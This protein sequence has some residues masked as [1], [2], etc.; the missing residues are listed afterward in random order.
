MGVITLLS[1]GHSRTVLSSTAMLESLSNVKH[2]LQLVRYLT[3]TRHEPQ[4]NFEQLKLGATTE[5]CL[6]C[7]QLFWYPP[8]NEVWMYKYNS[9]DMA[10]QFVP[11]AGPGAAPGATAP[12]AGPVASQVPL[13]TA[14]A[15]LGGRRYLAQGTH[16][17]MSTLIVLKLLLP[18]QL[19]ALSL[20]PGSSC[21]QSRACGYWIA[22]VQ[23][24]PRSS[25][26]STQGEPNLSLSSV[27]ASAL[28][29]TIA[30][31]MA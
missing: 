21:T 24:V 26:L 10:E 3:C 16:I 25:R 20:C 4:S 11:G 15:V 29:P 9:S 27:S 23:A 12:T 19:H 13:V 7:L 31:I 5:T 22:P 18:F 30:R 14:Q 28:S 1:V 6:A 8:L 2:I 17:V